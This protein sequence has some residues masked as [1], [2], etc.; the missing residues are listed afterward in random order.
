MNDL[1]RF[2][3]NKDIELTLFNELGESVYV[4][5]ASDIK[6]NKSTSLLKFPVPKPFKN[7][8]PWTLATLHSGR[9]IFTTFYIKPVYDVNVTT[10]EVVWPD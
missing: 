6:P 2:I 3:Q 1:Q 7:V 4:G 8:C 9:R 5:V 10:I